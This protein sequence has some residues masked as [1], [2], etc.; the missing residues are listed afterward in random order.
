VRFDI[1]CGGPVVA[2]LT[3][4]PGPVRR[5]APS[6]FAAVLLIVFF[7]AGG[8]ARADVFT[9]SHVKVDETAKDAASAKVKAIGAAQVIAFRRLI[10]RISP[11][12]SLD[13]L[14][15]FGVNDVSP[16]T[17]GLT[18]E[19]ERTSPTRYIATLTISFLPDQ[20]RE[21]LYQYSVPIAEEQAAQ[22]LLV[23]VWKT[24]NGL[25]LWEGENPWKEAWLALD[26]EH[27]LT[28]TLVPIGDLT[29]ISAIT[30]EEVLS[31]DSVKLEALRLRYGAENVVISVAEMKGDQ[32]LY[33][34]L[35]GETSF[36]LLNYGHAFPL[37]EDDTAKTAEQAAER[38]LFAMEESWKAA[39]AEL[40]TPSSNLNEITVAIP[41]DSLSEWNSLRASI[42]QTFG[43]AEVEIDSL[44][45]RGGIVKVRY[46]GSIQDL[47]EA[48]KVNGLILSDVGGTWVIQPYF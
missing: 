26:L 1:C 35:R 4:W 16:M 7:A 48:L 43:V 19:E 34:T 12:G 13:S 3:G 5:L 45:A 17:S 15:Q 41:F 14:P 8:I 22:I 46:E 10:Q 20:V 2:A 18:F 44:S 33:I 42:Q 27:S 29:D 31:R 40:R 28:P 36:G 38:F 21:L 23:P 6:I 39:V 25:A 24:A 47:S 30:A 9:V 37:R 11:A 32:S